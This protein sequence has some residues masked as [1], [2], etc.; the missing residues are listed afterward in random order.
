MRLTGIYLVVAALFLIVFLYSI[1]IGP[2]FYRPSMSGP[3]QAELWADILLR[4]ALL[5]I[6]IG[7]L[8]QA[9]EQR[10]PTSANI[11][12]RF[13]IS[14]TAIDLLCFVLLVLVFHLGPKS[15]A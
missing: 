10:Y 3:A 2:L 8:F 6:S 9:M 12:K 15:V 4:L 7:C 14:G 5:G 1:S 13:V 11:A